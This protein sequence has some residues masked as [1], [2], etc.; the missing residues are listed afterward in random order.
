MD[1]M[2]ESAESI[3]THPLRSS[4]KKQISLSSYPLI[5][6]VGTL[7]LSP[8]M[9]SDTTINAFFLGYWK[10]SMASLPCFGT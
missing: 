6:K 3:V 10:L 4:L 2:G 7:D 8:L 5:L 9:S 1:L